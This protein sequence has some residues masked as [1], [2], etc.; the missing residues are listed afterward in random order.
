VT[1]NPAK[2]PWY[3]LWLQEVVTDTTVRIGSFTVNGAFLG[4]VLLPGFL[5][6]LL[7]VWPWLDRSP[8][9]A[10][11]LWFPASRKKQNLVFLLVVL[12]VLVLTVIGTFLRGP[13]WH[14]YWPWEAWPALPTRI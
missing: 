10:A 6:A 1:P 5:I 12:L 13:Y 7:T 14:F 3:F 11:G 4:G 2:A 9:A 8:G